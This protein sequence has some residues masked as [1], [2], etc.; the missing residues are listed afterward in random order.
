M[1]KFCLVQDIFCLKIF[2][3]FS[4]TSPH[5]SGTNADAC[6]EESFQMLIL[7][8]KYIHALLIVKNS[9]YFNQEMTLVIWTYW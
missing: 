4:W 2:N 5:V 8:T 9:Q 3:T 1:V 6:K 7:Q